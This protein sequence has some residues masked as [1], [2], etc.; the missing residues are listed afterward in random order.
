[1]EFVAIPYAGKQ[2]KSS[3]TVFWKVKIWDHNNIEYSWSSIAR[4]TMGI[5]GSSE[6]KGQWITAPALAKESDDGEKKL[7]QS[8]MLRRDFKVKAGLK[9]AIAY[10][11][12]LGH[13]EMTVNGKPV[14]DNIC[15]VRFLA[16]KQQ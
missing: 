16:V 2:L 1:M 3:Q 11:C 9:R 4:W 10:V 15:S 7:Y 6:W 8:L 12:G 14:R 5:P 13:Y